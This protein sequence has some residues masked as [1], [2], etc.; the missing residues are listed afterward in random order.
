MIDCKRVES[1]PTSKEEDL[2][3]NYASFKEACKRL[4]NMLFVKQQIGEI[5]KDLLDIET[6]ARVR[7]VFDTSTL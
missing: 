6:Q 7:D 5:T 4:N 1:L 3:N 2:R